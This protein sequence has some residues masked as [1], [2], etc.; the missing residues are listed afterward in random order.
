MATLQ[1]ILEK[2]RALTGRVSTVEQK[3]PRKSLSAREQLHRI[4]WKI[5]R[6][7]WHWTQHVLNSST[8]GPTMAPNI[9]TGTSANSPTTATAATPPSSPSTAP[10]IKH[11]RK[12]FPRILGWAGEKLIGA[13]LPYIT[14][15]LI[16]LWALVWRYGEAMWLYLSGAWHWLVG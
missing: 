10:L 3:K 6:L 5:D 11:G 8:S 14:P 2:L 12:Y 9:S 15:I 1:T 16:S 4:E 7:G 13:A